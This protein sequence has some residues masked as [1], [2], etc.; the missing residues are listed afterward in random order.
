MSTWATSNKP[1]LHAVEISQHCSCGVGGRHDSNSHVMSSDVGWAPVRCRNFQVVSR[2]LISKS[3]LFITTHL[4]GPYQVVP[5][6]LCNT[7]PSSTLS[8]ESFMYLVYHRNSTTSLCVYIYMC[9]C[10]YIYIYMYICIYVYIYI[11]IYIYM[12]IYIYIYIYICMYIYVHIHIYI[13]IRMCICIYV[14]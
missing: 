7:Y 9:I 3:S 5:P 14:Y 6:F 1:P 2:L 10:I 8:K 4:R 12:Y 11:Y 13:Y